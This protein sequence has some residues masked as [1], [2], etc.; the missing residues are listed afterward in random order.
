MG[1]HS[2]GPG[3]SWAAGLRHDT[4]EAGEKVGGGMAEWAGLWPGIEALVCSVLK[5]SVSPAVKWGDCPLLACSRGCLP[6]VTRCRLHRPAL[7]T[8]ALAPEPGR[9]GPVGACCRP[10]PLDSWVG[11][12]GSC[13]THH[14]G[15]PLPPARLG[16]QRGLKGRFRSKKA[17]PGQCGQ[18]GE[19]GP[20]P[21]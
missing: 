6:D 16:S 5:A 18:E 1:R 20:V 4:P 9:A 3:V 7:K 15:R 13:R 12:H 10:Q 21:H 2:T 14:Q 11:W 8:G 19:T 17:A